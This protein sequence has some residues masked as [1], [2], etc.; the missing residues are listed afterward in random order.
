[1]FAIKCINLIGF[2]TKSDPCLLI[3]DL[4]K[5]EWNTGHELS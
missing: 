5:C 4:A 3:N 2:L 1:M